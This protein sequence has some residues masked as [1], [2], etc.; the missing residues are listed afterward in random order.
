MLRGNVRN[1]RRG[2]FLGGVEC[3]LLNCNF[4]FKLWPHRLANGLGRLDVICVR[5]AEET[6]RDPDASMEEKASS[7]NARKMLLGTRMK[8]RNMLSLKGDRC[9][10]HIIGLTGGK[11]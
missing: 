9:T 3:N 6:S 5:L 7:S 11:V 10:L 2:S 1:A 4:N 8:P